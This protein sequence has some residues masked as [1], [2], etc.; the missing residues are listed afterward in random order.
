MKIVSFVS[1]IVPFLACWAAPASAE[2]GQVF[3]VRK[4][5]RRRSQGA[6]QSCLKARDAFY[7]T[8]D[9]KKRDPL[10]CQWMPEGFEQDCL[11][12]ECQEV[13]LPI[14]QSFADALEFPCADDD[15]EGRCSY[16]YKLAGNEICIENKSGTTSCR[17]YPFDYDGYG[18]DWAQLDYDH[19][20]Q[21]NGYETSQLL[22]FKPGSCGEG[23]VDPFEEQSKHLV[24]TDDFLNDRNQVLN[25]QAACSLSTLEQASVGDARKTTVSIYE[26][27]WTMEWFHYVLDGQQALRGDDRS[28]NYNAKVTASVLPT[29]NRPSLSVLDLTG[30]TVMRGVSRL[31]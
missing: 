2:E 30:K 17:A 21:W 20:L 9:G 6:G 26:D 16:Y 22:L 12:E 15:D 31:A 24:L 3:C 8:E 18:T 27:Y 29:R 5:Y 4:A 23:A 1:T 28:V 14:S 13:N 25:Q 7:D 19:Q 10:A 11:Y